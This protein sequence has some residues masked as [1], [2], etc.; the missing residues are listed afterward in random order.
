MRGDY[1]ERMRAWAARAGA[2]AQ[3]VRYPRP[4]ARGEVCALRLAPRGEPR[5]RVVAAHGAG[6][7]AV[8]PLLALF[9]ALLDAG[10]EVFSFDVDGHGVASTTVFARDAVRT[11]VAAAVRVAEAGAPELPLHVLGHSL[12][13]AL[14]LDA[15]ASGALDRAA[16]AVVMS[17]PLRVDVDARTVLGELRGF[18]RAATLAQREH[19]GLWGLVPALGPLKRAAYPFRRADASP[20][21]WSYVDDVRA[22]LRELD[23]ENAAARIALPT[24]LVY[25]RADM[26]VRADQGVRL[27][28]R[29]PG[30]ELL[31]LD[32]ASHFGVPF[33]PA[34][35]ARTVEW[36]EAHAAVA[37]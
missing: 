11:S 16:S 35:V 30:A 3:T 28:A 1:A 24:L 33:H 19:Y 13:G 36:M 17:A 9:R 4:E 29:A 31:M 37:A 7:D 23:L 6:N 15:L 8:Y 34:A 25:G 2:R 10:A 5:M 27:A 12:G 14:V 21:A 18:F 26:L 20:G 32:G 22:L